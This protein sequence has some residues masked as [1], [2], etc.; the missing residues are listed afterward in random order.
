MCMNAREITVLMFR[1]ESH[2]IN[3]HQIDDSSFFI[4]IAGTDPQFKIVC[5][6]LWQR[7]AEPWRVVEATAGTSETPIT[8]PHRIIN[9][10]TRYRD[11]T[12]STGITEVILSNE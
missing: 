8:I 7:H 6:W 5:G 10:R 12:E 3:V 9:I 4:W 2:D 11:T 1:S